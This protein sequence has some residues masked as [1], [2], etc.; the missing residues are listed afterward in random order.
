MLHSDPSTHH[1]LTL[2]LKKVQWMIRK[3]D[4]LIREDTYCWDIV[5]QINA[6]IKLSSP[7]E[8]EAFVQ[9]FLRL[10]DLNKK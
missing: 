10:T 9:E 2:N 6:T 7:S 8:A 4:T 5:Q 3:I 1:I